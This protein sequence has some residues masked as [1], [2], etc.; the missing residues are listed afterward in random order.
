MLLPDCELMLEEEEEEDDVLTPELKDEV[1]AEPD[2]ELEPEPEFISEPELRTLPESELDAEPEAVDS[3]TVPPAG[4]VC[5]VSAVSVSNTGIF[6][7]MVSPRCNASSC[8][9]APISR[10]RFFL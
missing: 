10:S 5:D 9:A 3:L 4:C 6:I 8:A 7:S 2:V 1:E